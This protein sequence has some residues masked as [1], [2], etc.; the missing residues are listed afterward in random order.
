M[1]G[2]GVTVGVGVGVGIQSPSV[3]Q[4]EPGPTQVLRP[5]AGPILSK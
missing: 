2:V 4:I 5:S 3:V 1:V